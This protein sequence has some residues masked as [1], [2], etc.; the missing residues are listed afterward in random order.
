MVFLPLV[1]VAIMML[2][3]GKLEEMHKMLAL[4]FSLAT[5]V[6]GVLLMLPANF[7]WDTGQGPKLTI[8]QS[9]IDVVNVRYHVEMDGISLPLIALHR[10]A[11]THLCAHRRRG[12]TVRRAGVSLATLGGARRRRG[13]LWCWCGCCCLW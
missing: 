10:T 3:P 1:G 6:V 2:V 9:W 13:D 8:N 7:D 5:A 4:G 11:A 12:G